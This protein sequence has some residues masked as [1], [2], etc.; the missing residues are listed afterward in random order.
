MNARAALII[1]LVVAHVDA[2]RRQVLHECSAKAHVYDL[3][4]AADRE[5]WQIDLTR[6][7]EQSQL[8]FV[9]RAV[10]G[11]ELGVRIF[12]VAGR[13]DVFTPRQHETGNHVEQAR[14][15]FRIGK[16]RDDERYESG[17]LESAN[18][19]GVETNPLDAVDQADRR[20]HGDNWRIGGAWRASDGHGMESRSETGGVSRGGLRRPDA[21]AVGAIKSIS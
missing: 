7:S 11:P 9:A 14:R 17:R 2:L 1:E 13:I 18:V 4:S 20:G 12:A 19:C 21:V 5:R 16:R 8:R 15:R 10:Y 6:A 3:N